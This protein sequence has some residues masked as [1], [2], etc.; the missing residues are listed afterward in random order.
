MFRNE[1]G[2]QIWQIDNA[3]KG[4]A[5]TLTLSN[6]LKFLASG[7]NEGEVRIWEM[8]SREMISHLKEH[9]NKVTKVQLIGDDL[10]LLSSSRDRALLCWDLQ[11]EKR[12]S[13]HYQ[14][15]GGINYFD[16]IADKNLVL[17]TGQ[18]RKITYWD[19]RDP[20][21]LR[22]IDTNKNPKC[23]DECFGLAVSHDMK[24]FATGG[25]EQVVKLWD[26]GSGQLIAEGN[27]HSGC[28]RSVAFSY[29][30]KQLVSGGDDGNILLWNIFM[31]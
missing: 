25:S 12:I 27:G 29:D 6:N 13:A 20:N 11:K 8:K 3:H 18:D 16:I 31:N 1:T 7:G 17:T 9:T 23:G 14:R 26:V 30:D 15:M 10:H 24:L 2:K 21:P 4:G 19:L 22:S 5:I 28:I